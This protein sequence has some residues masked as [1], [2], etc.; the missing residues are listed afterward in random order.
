[1]NIFITVGSQKFQFDRLLRAVD[2]LAAEGKITDAIFAQTGSSA[3][4]PQQFPSQPFLNQ[5][6]FADRLDQADIVITH[7]GTG[8]IMN[9]VKRG[10]KVIAVPRLARYGEHVDDHQLELLRQFEQLDLICRWDDCDT[11]DEA[12]AQVKRTRYKPYQSNTRAILDSIEA[13][14]RSAFPQP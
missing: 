12:L 3:Y 2:R 9:A 10:K 4:I 13:F 6:E 1:M 14:I 5:E 8:V 7:G 11:L